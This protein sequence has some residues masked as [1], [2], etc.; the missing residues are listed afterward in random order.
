MSGA[1][2]MR[3][4]MIGAV[5]CAVMATSPAAWGVQTSHWVQTN[6]TDFKAGKFENVV[7]TN[8]GDLKLSREVK[9]LLEQDSRVSVVYCLAEAPDG[10]I[11]AGTGPQGVLLAVKDGKVSTAATLKEGENIFSVL[12]DAKGAILVG[13]G[14][15]HGRVL[16]I[17]K[18]GDEPKEVF[19]EQD[20]QYVWALRQTPDGNVYAATGPNGQL[21]EITPDGKH[22]VLFDSDENNLLSLISDGKDLLYVGTDPN[23]LVYRINRKT[24]ESFVL[25][26]A[27][28]SEVSCLA[29]GADGTLYAGTSDALPEGGPAE[30]EKVAERA[31]RPETEGGAVE[32]P[33]KTPAEP[34]PPP[35]PD[36]NPPRPN[37]I[38]KAA[39]AEDA[40]ASGGDAK[41]AG[42]D[43]ESPDGGDS[44]KSSSA[45]HDTAAHDAGAA[46]DATTMAAGGPVQGEGKGNAI[47]RIDRDGFV[48]EV[49]RENVTIFSM[50]EHEGTLLVG[51]GSDGEVYQVSPSAE[52]TVVLAKVDAKQVM[53]MLVS[54][55]GQVYM[56]FA[57]TGGIG[58]M[59]S[60]FAKSGTYTSA[61]LDANQISR[62]GKVAMTGSLPPGTALTVSTRSGNLSSPDQKGWSEWS[63]PVPAAQY[64]DV[65]AQAA[66][67]LQYRLNFSTT[68]PKTTP[69]VD[70]V[71]VAYEM[72]NLAPRVSQVKFKSDEDK[73]AAADSGGPAAG[74]GEGDSAAPKPRGTGVQTI[75]WEASDPNG[76]ALS[77]DLYY[78]RG[79]RAPWILLKD[80]VKETTY[81]WDTH[82]IADGEYE[83]KVVASDEAANP[84]G[85]GKKGNRVSDPIFVDNTPPT[86]GDLKWVKAKGAVRIQ[87]RAVDRASTVANVEYAVDSSDHWQAV[88]PSDNIFDSPEEAV[89]FTVPDLKPG[90]HQIAIRATDAH[91]NQAFESILVTVDEPA[92]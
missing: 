72:P 9:Q 5:L 80:R 69:V 40:K 7:A 65:K 54:S 51:T 79:P 30:E 32:I 38:P 4:R 11:Y 1:M 31:G 61:V 91:G 21:F 42:G 56:G 85:S 20:V 24:K 33:S 86:I 63:E 23:G 12:V 6:A 74:G 68:D 27:N 55:S 49:F 34:S 50:T 46:H 70:Q 75:T 25:Y 35:V 37:P 87:L 14:G 60:G 88:L 64:L 29:L 57:N 82:T 41:Q 84:L 58:T 71:D 78:R 67:F 77:Y 16:R 47:Y 73:G 10:T 53:T 8:L 18:P 44:G 90:Q 17:E 28:E 3:R 92:R 66:R 19:A 59:S 13:T 26:D 15:N 36:P 45:K 22:S 48:T 83:I 89:V 2:T 81:K 39:P 62:F 76:D 52:E 43:A